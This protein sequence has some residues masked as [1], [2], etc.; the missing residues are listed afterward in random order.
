MSVVDFL[1][2]IVNKSENIIDL[3]K[4]YNNYCE[5]NV[6]TIFVN[7]NKK[8]VCVEHINLDCD[9]INLSSGNL[10]SLISIPTLLYE[11]FDYI[12][13]L[14]DKDS[15]NKIY[16]CNFP[17]SNA[18]LLPITNDNENIG[19]VILGNIRNFNVNCDTLLEKILPLVGLTQLILTKKQL[20]LEKHSDD[21]YSKD[22]FLANMSHEIRTPLNGVIGYNQ[23]LLQTELNTTQRGYLNSMN[24]CSLQLMQILNDILDFSKLSSGKM[25]I[26]SECFSIKE[27]IES[28]ESAMGQR[29]I[30]KKQKVA[31]SILE[32]IPEFIIMDKQKLIQII[33]N[34]VSNAN[35]F[36]DINGKIDV[37]FSNPQPETLKII[38]QDTGI[39]ISEHN[40]SK[41]FNTFEQINDNLCKTG[42]GLGLAICKKLVN[43]LGGEIEVVSKLEKGSIFSFTT[44][45]RP[46]EDYMKNIEHDAKLLKGKIVLVVDD[47]TDNRILL[48]EMLFEWEMIPIVCASALEALRMIMGKRYTFSLGLIDIC[49]PGTSGGELARQIKE[50]DP[51]FPLIAL[52]S[53]DSFV[54][55]NHF[56]KKLDKPI[57]KIQL[58][59]SIHKIISKSERPSAYIGDDICFLHKFT[60]NKINKNLKILIAEDM[61]HNRILLKNML[62]TLEYTNIEMAENGQQAIINITKNRQ[63]STPYDILLLDLRMP[64]ID[65]Y[66]VIE[67]LKKRKYSLPKV[68]AIT[69]SVMDS[70]KNKCLSLGVKYFITKP[71]DLQQLKEVLLHVSTRLD[72]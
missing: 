64:I 8:Y 45:F 1:K 71:I 57:N 69:A 18:I 38:V 60:S 10:S 30:E 44:K 47:N 11:T 72:E 5:C 46:Y 17:I 66:G 15:I 26:N 28:V 12:Q 42:T 22:I 2:G 53:V 29:F 37:I 58:F 62:E 52:S 68:I 65:G 36:T 14:D 61:N 40:I 43:L 70:D 27:I 59:N 51:F 54:S 24:Q 35:K 19:V 20:L 48:S 63:E 56:E 32:N 16:N 50:E 41:L 23:L 49:M 55:S 9:N 13:I 3:I 39:G 67:F 33:I 4:L 31:F 34:L 21:S 25:G 6:V 7:S